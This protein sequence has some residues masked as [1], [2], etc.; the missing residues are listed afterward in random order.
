MSHKE[1]LSQLK[2]NYAT[3]ADALRTLQDEVPDLAGSGENGFFDL[4]RPTLSKLYE[5]AKMTEAFLQ[6]E[7]APSSSMA[8]RMRNFASQSV[9]ATLAEKARELAE[10]SCAT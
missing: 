7:L 2:R 10:Q 9:R 3:Y 1:R 8:W 6:R 4:I 5:H